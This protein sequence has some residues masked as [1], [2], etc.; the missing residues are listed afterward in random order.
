M[1]HGKSKQRGILTKAKLRGL[2]QEYGPVIRVNGLV[3]SGSLFLVE[4]CRARH[5]REATLLACVKEL[6]QVHGALVNGITYES[7]TSRQTALWVAAT[8][9]MTTIVRYLLEKGANPYAP[10]CTGRV[11]YGPQQRLS[12]YRQDVSVLEFTKALRDAQAKVGMPRN[13]L[14]PLDSCIGLLQ[15]STATMAQV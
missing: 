7:A 1:V 6:I 14:S 8:R 2:F 11:R 13:V 15:Q 12:L 3:T 4:L 10:V 5:V 9:G